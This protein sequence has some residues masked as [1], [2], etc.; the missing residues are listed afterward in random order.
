MNR[1][2]PWMGGRGVDAY[3]SKVRLEHREHAWWECGKKQI[4]IF[5]VVGGARGLKMKTEENGSDRFFHVPKTNW[6]QFKKIK[7]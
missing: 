3:L 5:W 4:L 7:F 6:L 2:R 1:M